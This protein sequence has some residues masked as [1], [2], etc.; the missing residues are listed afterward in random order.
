MAF[1]VTSRSTYSNTTGVTSAATTAAF[2]PAANSLMIAF[3][4]WSGGD[5]SSPPNVQ[6]TGATNRYT[7][8][9]HSVSGSRHE[10][11]VAKSGATPPN[12]TITAGTWAG[13]TL[14]G[15]N[16]SVIEVTGADVSGTALQ[17]IVQAPAQAT[18]TSAASGSYTASATI[19]AAASNT[20]NR[21]IMAITQ[22]GD[23]SA[24]SP[25]ANWTEVSEGGYSSPS[26]RLEVQF[27]ADAFETTTEATWTANSA[28]PWRIIA[29]EIKAAGG[30]SVGFIPI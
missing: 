28:I 27:R 24:M 21:P 16:I 13:G 11:W 1:V 23:N 26:T 20:S 5:A 3:V 8:T 9:K 18:G 6:T 7:F 30:D 29:A 12:D 2:T 14:T 22:Q 19:L 25:R 4:S 15:L 10:L 17:A